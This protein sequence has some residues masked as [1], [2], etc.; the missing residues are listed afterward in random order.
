MSDI[1]SFHRLTSRI[2][3][4][5]VGDRGYWFNIILIFRSTISIPDM[6]SSSSS[7]ISFV[8]FWLRR[9]FE[10]F[11]LSLLVLWKM[12]FCL[13]NA[14]RFFLY[15]TIPVVSRVWSLLAVWSVTSSNEFSNFSL[16]W[17]QW[18]VLGDQKALSYYRVLYC[19]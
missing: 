5:S 16:Y 6:M 9:L 4:S 13:V 2:V 8:S 1:I 3:A 10:S 7:V 19:W 18:I 15:V 12:L 14:I 17:Y 11:S